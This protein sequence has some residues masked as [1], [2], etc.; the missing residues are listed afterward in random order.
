MMLPMSSL[1]PDLDASACYR[2]LCARDARFDGC[3][4]TG[5]TSTGI[6]CRP[7]CR[8]KTPKADNCRF[9]R[10]AAQAEHAGFRPCLRC[11]PELAP[12]MPGLWAWSTQDASAHLVGQAVRMLDTALSCN[13]ARFSVEQLAQR[14]GITSRHLRRLFETHLG[15]SPHQYWQTRRLLMA[16]RLLTDTQLSVQT[17]AQHSGFASTRTLH[18]AFQRHYGLSP[19][20]VRKTPYTSGTLGL[21]RL[22]YRPPL[23]H[24]RLLDFFRVRQL[25]AIEFV[26]LNDQFKRTG[27]SFSIKIGTQIHTGWLLADFVPEQARVEVRVSESLHGALPAVIQQ[28]RAW[29]DL[30]ADPQQLGQLPLPEPAAGL[31]VPGTL[32]PFALAVRAIL[33]QQISVAAARRLAQR[34]VE[35]FGPALAT[36]Y[37]GSEGRL[38]HLFPTAEALAQLPSECLGS[39]GIVRQRQ[40]AILALARAVA[41]QKLTLQHPDSLPATLS[42]LTDLPGIG[43]WTAQYI[44]M[45]ALRWPDAFPAADTALHKG[46]G[47][48]NA[49][50]ALAKAAP[51]APW[52]AYAC[53]HWWHQAAQ[54]NRSTTSP[55]DLPAHA[56][57]SHRRDTQL[58][59]PPGPHHP[60]RNAPGPVRCLV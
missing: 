57:S 38:T 8:V 2:A 4:F 39:L 52:R 24:E 3:F 36:P 11:R 18:T 1:S 32:D 44:A 43:D 35:Q 53:Q 19:G 7:V 9:F 12:V 55:L 29:L 51:Y 47:V 45:R 60:G 34:L 6:Y 46:M 14:L 21:L 31:R 58:P 22:P 16:K 5:V 59:E 48:H 33:G 49:R 13:E 27:S 41:H 54:L 28:V 40:I 25:N 10:H 56:S 30:D 17:V 37:T 20:R 23:D 42:A 15:V 26:A 50:E